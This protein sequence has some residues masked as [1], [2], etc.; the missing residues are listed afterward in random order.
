MSTAVQASPAKELGFSYKQGVNWSEYLDFRP[1]Y[2]PSFFEHIYTYHAQ[3]PNSSWSVAHDI[4]AG[5]GV[6]SAG[7]ASKFPRVIVSDPNDGFVTLAQTLLEKDTASSSTSFR[8]LQEGAEKS[9]V[10]AGTVDV[11]IAA[12][13]IQWTDTATAIREIRRELKVGGTSVI[14][15]YTVPR[16]VGNNEAQKVWKAIWDEY[17][18]RAT[19]PLLDH[20]VSI[21]NTALDCLEFPEGEWEGVRRIHVN[22]Q[23][24]LESYR[25][26]SRSRESKVRDSEEVAWVEG[27][28]DWA[29][30]QGLAWFKGYLA[31]WVP[32]VPE[33]EIQH[34]WAE[35]ETA[36]GGQKVRIET[37]LTIVFATKA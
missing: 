12:E 1:V 19:G 24:S 33:Q 23:G 16:I 29:D 3:K 21:V 5:C 11:A 30:E 6:V 34:L 35:L 15:H 18:R 2:P 14:T 26:D 4:G 31:T 36:L 22:A 27:D 25:L 9:S 32:V 10:D 37:P 17:A 20:A 7:L 8:F 13:C 28:D